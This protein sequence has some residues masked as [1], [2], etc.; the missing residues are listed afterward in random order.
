M[1]ESGISLNSSSF[2]ISS[3]VLITFLKNSFGSLGLFTQAFSMIES[4]ISLNSSSFFISSF[5]LITFLK[6]SFGSLGLCTQA[7]SMIES[8]RTEKSF[9]KTSISSMVK[10]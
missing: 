10:K 7:Y 6:N 5:V 4:G 2:F 9:F 1:I 3:F 8:G